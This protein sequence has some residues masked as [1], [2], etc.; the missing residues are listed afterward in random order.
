[1]WP[2]YPLKLGLL[3]SLK[4]QRGWKAGKEE[5][6]GDLARIGGNYIGQSRSERKVDQRV[7]KKTRF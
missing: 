5:R 7:N 6:N 4:R 1:M 3:I 2:L